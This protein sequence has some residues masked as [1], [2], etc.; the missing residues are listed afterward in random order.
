[1]RKDYIPVKDTEFDAFQLNLVNQVTTNAMVWNILLTALT[2]LA[3]LQAAWTAAWLVA[4][5][6]VNRSPAVIAA[7]RQTRTTYEAALRNF[8]QANIYHNTTMND[9]DIELCG[10]RPYD[11][12][13]TPIPVPTTLPIVN[14]QRAPGNFFVVRY[15]RLEDETGAIHRGKPD[16]V[17]KI[18]FAYSLNMQPANPAACAFNKVSTRGP[19]RVEIPAGINGQTVWFYARWKNVYDAAGPWTD[20][21]SFVL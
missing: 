6:K 8:I 14:L 11:R 17:A 5:V 19:I 1:M 15:F 7:K 9:G 4:Q 13:R 12:T 2:A 10:L 18:E 16:K 21:D 3:P 20:L